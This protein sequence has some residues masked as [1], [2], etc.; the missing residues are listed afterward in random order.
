[1]YPLKIDSIEIEKS[2]HNTRQ[3]I[4]QEHGLSSSLRAALEV[5]L[6]LVTV[7]INRTALT[8]KN[9]SKLPS[10]D[11]N[12]L[13]TSRKKSDK[14][15]GAQTGYMVKTLEKTDDPDIV[16]FIPIDRRALPK[17]QYHQVGIETRQVFDIDILRIITEYQAEV[18]KDEMGHRFVATFP[19]GATKTVQYGNQINLKNKKNL[20]NIKTGTGFF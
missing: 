15:S 12:R 7:L 11:P 20:P 1:M 14:P 17:G 5:L 4:D 19:E 16:E 3:L 6:L 9:S 2:L 13:K 18:L 10:S 8:S